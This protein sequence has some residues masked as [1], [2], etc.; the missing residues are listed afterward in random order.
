[1]S[2][3]KVLVTGATG[4][5][6]YFVVRDLVRSGRQVSCFVRKSS[7]IS[8]LAQFPVTFLYG[9]LED[10]NSLTEALSGQDILVNVA[11]LGFGHASNILSACR[12]AGIRRA[13][14]FSTTAI[15]TTLN[16]KS[17]GPR[18][19]AE[20]YIQNSGLDYTILRPTMIYGTG[21]D[22]NMCRLV[23]LIR[24]SPIIPVFGTGNYLQQPVYV[25]DLAKAVIQVLDHTETTKGKCYNLSGAAPLTYNE[26]VKTIAR[27]HKKPVWILH[28]PVKLSILLIKGAAAIPKL[29]KLKEEQILRLNE[30]K[31]FSHEEAVTDF[32][33]APLT[34]RE[35]IHREIQQMYGGML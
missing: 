6:G 7:D 28:L 34:F 15:F 27:L 30:H 2:G 1:M 29:P 12:K 8:S 4:F 33:Y 23:R 31:H 19:E 17:K 18:T 13:V 11:S 5:L 10:E 3:N 20:T 35:G 26:V 14:F 9:E 24:T 22:R 21:K 25:E 16:A 32:G